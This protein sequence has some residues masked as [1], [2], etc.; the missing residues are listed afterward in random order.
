MMWGGAY[1]NSPGL[2]RSQDFCATEMMLNVVHCWRKKNSIWP[3]LKV[4]SSFGFLKAV[5]HLLT[6]LHWFDD[7]DYFNLDY[8]SFYL[9]DI[10]Y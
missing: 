5:L 1:T 8:I 2:V 3:R 10:N 9:P 7:N 6:A 4:N